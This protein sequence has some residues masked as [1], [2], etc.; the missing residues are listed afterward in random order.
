[1]RL[2]FNDEPGYNWVC[3]TLTHVTTPTPTLHSHTP[4]IHSHTHLPCVKDTGQHGDAVENACQFLHGTLHVLIV[5]C[6]VEHTEWRGTNRLR[7]QKSYRALG[8]RLE[9][10]V[11]VAGGELE[12]KVEVEIRCNRREQT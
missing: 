10:D 4:I 6:L 9:T 7:G 5:C 11:G 3:N 8:Y 1:M 2:S 12:K